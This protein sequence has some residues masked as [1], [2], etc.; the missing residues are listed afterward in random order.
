MYDVDGLCRGF[1]KRCH[2]T[3][4]KGGDRLVSHESQMFRCGSLI[5]AS[6]WGFVLR[7][8][9]EKNGAPIC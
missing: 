3:I 7:M 8:E 5:I 1:I 4:E 6:D 9:I 2:A